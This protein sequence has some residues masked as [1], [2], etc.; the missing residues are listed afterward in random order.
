M[1][2]L[3]YIL[4]CAFVISL[5]ACAHA[6]THPAVWKK[7]VIRTID[8]AE[9]KDGVRLSS[10]AAGDSSLIQLV[11]NAALTKKMTIYSVFDPSLSTKTSPDIL[12]LWDCKMDTVSVIDS[13]T[14]E[15]VVKLKSNDVK[16]EHLQKLGV[17]EDWTFDPSGGTTTIQILGIGPVQDIYG[18]DGT[19]RGRRTLF[20][21]KY[22]DARKIIDRYERSHPNNT[23]A[24]HIWSDYFSDGNQLPFTSTNILTQ[25]CTRLVE[26]DGRN[27]ST[28][29]LKNYYADYVSSL[30]DMLFRPITD[31]VKVNSNCCDTLKPVQKRSGELM[32]DFVGGLDTVIAIDP[33]TGE[34]AIRSRSACD[35]TTNIFSIAEKW[36][37]N[38]IAGLTKINIISLGPVRKHYGF[39]SPDLF[40]GPYFWMRYAD[41]KPI[42]ELYEQYHPDN[43]LALHIWNNYFLSDKK[44]T[45]VK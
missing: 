25:Y 38:A 2:L 20:W 19:F 21:I 6:Q 9:R 27:D 7:R 13:I 17:S 39:N 42:L 16:Y 10:N 40:Y 37:F 26:L 18:D 23:V 34:E 29:Y 28:N 43:T 4:W 12:P 36:Q 41:M 31:K 35:P 14:G 44:P 33:I 45:P 24:G 5:P 30:F 1:K 11:I 3:P 15:T 32:V 22:N 8:L